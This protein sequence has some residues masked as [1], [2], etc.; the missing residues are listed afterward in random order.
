MI[1]IDDYRSSLLKYLHHAVTI[2]VKME[3]PES[4]LT[5]DIM[6]TLDSGSADKLGSLMKSYF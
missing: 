3:P 5:P 6:L 1:R 4:I 2:I